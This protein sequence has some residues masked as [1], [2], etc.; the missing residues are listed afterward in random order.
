M[1]KDNNGVTE[2][3]ANSGMVFN[4]LLSSGGK[5]ETHSYWIQQLMIKLSRAVSRKL[6][7]SPSTTEQLRTNRKYVYSELKLRINKIRKYA[8]Y[9]YL[10]TIFYQ[11]LTK[12]LLKG[13]LLPCK[14]VSFTPQKS[15][16]YHAKGH[17]LPCQSPPAILNL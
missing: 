9:S 17:L 2:M 13:A 4:R 7:V 11:G 12:A 16:F 1:I 10:Y 15:T 3:T 8:K 6:S 14:R 5:G